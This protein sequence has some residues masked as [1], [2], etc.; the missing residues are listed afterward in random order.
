MLQLLCI[1]FYKEHNIFV[2]K[3]IRNNI[4]LRVIN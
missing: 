3:F 2:F 1:N 4:I